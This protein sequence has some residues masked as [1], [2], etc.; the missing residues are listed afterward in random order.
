MENPSSRPQNC[1]LFSCGGGSSELKFWTRFKLPE[2]VLTN[3][4]VP[5]LVEV[6]ITLTSGDYSYSEEES[7][8]IPLL[9]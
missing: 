3:Q 9:I 4:D 7:D 8:F 2:N 5:V 1:I 6:I